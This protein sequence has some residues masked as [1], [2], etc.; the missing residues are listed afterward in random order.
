MRKKMYL[1]LCWVFSVALLTPG[2]HYM[3]THT[4]PQL[5]VDKILKGPGTTLKIK[6]KRKGGEM[7][8]SLCPSNPLPPPQ[9]TNQIIP[10]SFKANHGRQNNSFPNMSTSQSVG[11]VMLPCL[12]KRHSAD[13][14]KLRILRRRD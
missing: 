1:K 12:A 13:I 10:M 11:P 14:I 5:D 8:T 9:G 3:L 6:T 2:L 4:V 7:Y